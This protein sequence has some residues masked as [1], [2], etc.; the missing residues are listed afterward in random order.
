MDCFPC[1]VAKRR[2]EL[3]LVRVGAPTAEIAARVA[4]T[5]C[6]M[7]TE[8]DRQQAKRGAPRPASP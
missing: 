6:A 7:C 3:E 8:A 4:A 1:S 2:V 5:R